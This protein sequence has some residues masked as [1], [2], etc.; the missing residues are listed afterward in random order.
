MTN[1]VLNKIKS[2]KLPKIL[3][4]WSTEDVWH[5]LL[6]VRSSSVA[7][8][9]AD[10]HKPVAEVAVKL[11]SLKGR[12]LLP[13]PGIPGNEFKAWKQLEMDWLQEYGPV[14]SLEVLS[15][16]LGR[17]ECQI[18][19]A[20]Q[21]NEIARV[22]PE[23]ADKVHISA[24]ELNPDGEGHVTVPDLFVPTT[25]PIEAGSRT[26]KRW[27]MQEHRFIQSVKDDY[28]MHEIASFIG[29][30]SPAVAWRLSQMSKNKIKSS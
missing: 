29:R 27:T 24:V 16:C 8:I 3:S 25:K 6:N 19:F 4:E 22:E 14:Y 12:D 11:S 20:L 30:T 7:E 18:E 17:S 21:E 15:Q 26:G 2:L 23:K 9:A 28:T 5:L 10:L 1:P 13:S